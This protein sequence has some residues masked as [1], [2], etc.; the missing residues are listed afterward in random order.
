MQRKFNPEVTLD[1]NDGTVLIEFCD[2]T[3]KAIYVAE[4]LTI[5]RRLGEIFKKDAGGEGSK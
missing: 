3:K 5:K 4:A 2:G 1:S